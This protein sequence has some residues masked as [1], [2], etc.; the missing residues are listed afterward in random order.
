[1]WIGYTTDILNDSLVYAEHARNGLPTSSGAAAAAIASQP[2]IPS[3]D[4]IRL[5]VQARTEGSSVSKEVS[6]QLFTI[7]CCI[8]YTSYVFDDSNAN[9]IKTLNFV[10]FISSSYFN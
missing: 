6:C 7:I 2:L 9:I 10:E 5:A 1:M 3:L 4:D 8:V